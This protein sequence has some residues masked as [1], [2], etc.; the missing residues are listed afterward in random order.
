[1]RLNRGRPR[2]F[3]SIS[4]LSLH[5][6]Q[7]GHR[8]RIKALGLCRIDRYDQ[9]IGFGR[10][11][12]RVIARR[13]RLE[14]IVEPWAS[15]K[16]KGWCIYFRLF[17]RVHHRKIIRGGRR[18]SWESNSHLL[19]FF[20]CISLFGEGSFCFFLL[21]FF[22]FPSEMKKRVGIGVRDERTGKAVVLVTL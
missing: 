19:D 12:L 7:D 8:D 17:P 13:K 5:G 4:F 21:H 11:G 14:R 16:G 18:W 10:Q 9:G 15:G 1:M 6:E 20:E 3:P 22:Y 2:A